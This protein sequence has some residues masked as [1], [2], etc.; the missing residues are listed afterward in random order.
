MHEETSITQTVSTTPLV[1]DSKKQLH[2]QITKNTT[3]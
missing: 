3:T 2:K 1:K